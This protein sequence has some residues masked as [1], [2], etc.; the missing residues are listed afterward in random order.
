MVT[1]SPGSCVKIPG[2][3]SSKHGSPRCF[4]PYVD[5]FVARLTGGLD[6]SKSE[7]HSWKV[8]ESKN[9]GGQ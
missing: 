7:A 8:R 6:W 4:P 5:D 9:S 2:V 1:E 3:Y